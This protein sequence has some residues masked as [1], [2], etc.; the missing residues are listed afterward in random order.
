MSAAV[1]KS[2]GRRNPKN[3]IIGSIL[4]VAVTRR[5]TGA[6]FNRA[7]RIYLNTLARTT[8]GCWPGSERRDIAPLL[9]RRDRAFPRKLGFWGIDV[10]SMESERMRASGFE[11]AGTLGGEGVGV[12]GLWEEGNG[13]IGKLENR[14]MRE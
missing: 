8:A 5:S 11:Y 12:E 3:K 4:C 2:R 1:R 14:G 10:E 6:K 7:S 9:V 13:G